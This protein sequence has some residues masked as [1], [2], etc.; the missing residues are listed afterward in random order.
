M[1]SFKVQG[2]PKLVILA[3]D[4]RLLTDNG[5]SPALSTNMVEHWLQQCNL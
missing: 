4:G 2:I 1:G 3:P 5:V